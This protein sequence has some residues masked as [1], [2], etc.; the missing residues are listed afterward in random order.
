INRGAGELAQLEMAGEKVSVKMC[1]KDPANLQ[2]VTRSGLDIHAD[3][4]LRIDDDRGLAARI[5]DEIRRVCQTLQV[6]LFEDH[7]CWNTNPMANP[8]FDR[9]GQN[10]CEFR[11]DSTGAGLVRRLGGNFLLDVARHL[12]MFVD[13]TAGLA[14]PGLDL[15]IMTAGGFLVK[16]HRV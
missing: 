6:K 9:S 13:H 7:C 12:E 16:R 15:G 4:A 1:E 11:P 3:V 5:T 14:G 8:S 10:S 2:A